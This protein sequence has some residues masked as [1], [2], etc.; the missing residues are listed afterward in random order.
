[1][2]LLATHCQ[3]LSTKEAACSGFD[4]DL[5][6]SQGKIAPRHL[7]IT[8]L[9]VTHTPPENPQSPYT[10]FRMSKSFLTALKRWQTPP[11][12]T[13]PFSLVRTHRARRYRPATYTPQQ[14]AMTHTDII[15]GH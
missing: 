2:T 15:T 6:G 5:T 13:A 7:R 12:R 3:A 8:S 14:V 10:N 4:N 11:R 9:L 1:M